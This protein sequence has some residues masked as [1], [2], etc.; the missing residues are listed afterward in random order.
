ME[1][2]TNPL[3]TFDNAGTLAAWGFLL[4]YF[5]I[6]IAAPVY[7]KKPRRTRARRTSSSR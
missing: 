7:L 2:F 4:A 1:I 3:N 5:A 6:S